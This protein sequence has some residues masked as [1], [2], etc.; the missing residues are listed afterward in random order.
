M[1]HISYLNSD[2]HT[3]LLAYDSPQN[4]YCARQ[5]EQNGVWV[6]HQ[7]SVGRKADKTTLHIDK[8]FHSLLIHLDQRVRDKVLKMITA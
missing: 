6:P 1:L 5:P 2:N 4:H 8:Y 3:S 7:H